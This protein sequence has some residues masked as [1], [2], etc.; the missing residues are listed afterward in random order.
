L[1]NNSHREGQ[2]VGAVYSKRYRVRIQSEMKKQHPP[3]QQIPNESDDDFE[4]ITWVLPPHIA[5]PLHLVPPLEND[6]DFVD[7]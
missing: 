1:E 7:V 5:K 3:S 4:N 2:G 6:D